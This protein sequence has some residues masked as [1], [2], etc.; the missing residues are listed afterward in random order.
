[1]TTISRGDRALYICVLLAVLAAVGSI[2]W[3]KAAQ[4]LVPQYSVGDRFEGAPGLD[5]KSHPSTMVIW[6]SSRC[7]ACTA[8]M[9]FY[10]RLTAE[11]HRTPVVLMGQESVDMLKAYADAFAFR[12]AQIVSAGDQTLKFAGTPT[13][14]L[15]GPDSIVRSIWYGRRQNAAEESEILRRME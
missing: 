15:I 12:P 13:V 14:L 7:G 11:S 1:M 6:V 4:R 3:A 8:S 2:V 10:Q 9:P 5:F